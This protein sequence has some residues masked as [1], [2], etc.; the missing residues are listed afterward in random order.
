MSNSVLPSLS[1]SL[2]QH[3]HQAN[4]LPFIPASAREIARQTRRQSAQ[5]YRQS[6]RA[7]PQSNQGSSIAGPSAG[8]V[9]NLDG[10]S[11]ASE[12]RGRRRGASSIGD[13]ILLTASLTG[14]VPAQVLI[15]PLNV[16][17]IHALPLIRIILTYL[18]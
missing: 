16:S 8:I 18:D 13:R 7:N 9:A 2:A 5:R 15:Y 6:G 11:D 4:P 1:F 12:G 10:R 17:S 14:E 3:D